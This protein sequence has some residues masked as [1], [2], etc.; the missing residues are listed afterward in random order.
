LISVIFPKDIQPDIAKTKVATKICQAASLHIKLPEDIT[1]EFVDLAQGTYGET[2]L[3]SN[4]IRLN[5]SL[6][7]KELIYPLVHE[8]LHLNQIHTGKLS[9]RYNVYVYEGKKYKIDQSTMTHEEYASLPWEQDVANREKQLL[10][11]IL[12]IKA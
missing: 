4:R 9:M 8:L 2:S 7:V 5:I 11:K 12:K 6:S 1:I 3:S 10:V